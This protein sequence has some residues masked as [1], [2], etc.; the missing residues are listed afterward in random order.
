VGAMSKKKDLRIYEA[1]EADGYIQ[2]RIEDSAGVV[3]DVEV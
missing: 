3:G 2:V 1:R